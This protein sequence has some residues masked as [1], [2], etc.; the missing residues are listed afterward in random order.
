[1]GK[2]VGDFIR[3]FL[4]RLI[5]AIL[6]TLGVVIL[7]G[8][9][10]EKLETVVFKQLMAMLGTG[11]VLITAI[12]GTPIHELSHLVGCW[13]FGFDVKEV[14]LLRPIAYKADGVL[15][16]VSYAYQSDN[17]WQK[18]G[19]FVTAFGPMIFGSLFIFLFVWLLTPEVFAEIKVRF[20][21]SQEKRSG[22]AKIFAG[23]WAAFSGFFIGFT[24][25]RKWGILRGIICLYVVMSISMHMTLSTQDLKS[26]SVGVLILLA[27]YAVYSLI[28]TF[29]GTNYVSSGAKVAAF[30]SAVL[31]IGLIFDG[32]LLALALSLGQIRAVRGFANT[33][34]NLNKYMTIT[35]DGTNGSGVAHAELDVEKITKKYD[36]ELDLSDPEAAMQNAL[37]A[38]NT[39]F[40]IATCVQYDIE[41]RTGLK[42]GDVVTL[43]WKCDDETAISQYKYKLRY[44]DIKYTVSGLP[45]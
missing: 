33:H 22:I 31:S 42:N 40:L 36:K 21:N 29:F 39:G 43:T 5:V 45:D 11:A 20:S 6:S 34:I 7:F 37:N 17:I 8:F 24:K 38:M 12:V 23:W 28:T 26:A 4:L 19:C 44:K 18:L 27:T 13:L 30:I 14:A 1:M 2:Q 9:V 35:V 15:G 25:L 10:L 3:N 41:P 32:I 16:Y